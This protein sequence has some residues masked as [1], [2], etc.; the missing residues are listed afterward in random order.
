MRGSRA[1]RRPAPHRGSRTVPGTMPV[2]PRSADGSSPAATPA[3]RTR[4]A[5]SRVAER[6]LELARR[7]CP[8]WRCTI[9][10]GRTR[11][12]VASSNDGVREPGGKHSPRRCRSAPRCPNTHRS[13]PKPASTSP[14]FGQHGCRACPYRERFAPRHAR[15]RVHRVQQPAYTPQR[16]TPRVVRSQ[17]FLINRVKWRIRRYELAPLMVSHPIRG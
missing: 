1:S 16:L 13:A 11:A 2:S 9:A 6:R 7:G 10:S 17:C 8:S 4:R 5:P 14:A 15:L 12:T 3:A